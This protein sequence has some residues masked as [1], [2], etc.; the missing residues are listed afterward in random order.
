MRKNVKKQRTLFNFF[1]LFVLSLL[2]LNILYLSSCL[3]DDV[4]DAPSEELIFSVDTLRFDTVFT[5]VGSVTRSVRV[6]NPSDQNIS[7]GSITFE[8]N[9]MSKFRM[10]VD[11]LSGDTFEDVEIRARDSLYIFVEVTIDPDEPL[12][13]SP[14]IMTDGILIQGGNISQK[15]H[16]EAWGQNA[17]YIPSRFNSG[18]VTALSCR[19]STVTFD[20]PRPYVIYGVL[21]IDSCQVVLPAGTQVYV[22]GG[23]AD[24]NGTITNDGG[25]FFFENASMTS[26]G[27]V[28]APVVFQGDRLEDGFKDAA[29]QWRG[30]R[31]TAGSKNNILSHTIVK[32]AVIGVQADSASSVYIEKSQIFN[33]SSFGV[34]GYHA[35]LEINNSLIHTNS[36]SSMFF[37]NGGNYNV[38]YSTIAN[39]GNQDPGIYIDN[40]S[41]TD[42]ECFFNPLYARLTNNIITGSNGDEILYDDINEGA[43][44]DGFD[45]TFQNNLVKIEELTDDPFFTSIC[46]N[47][48]SVMSSDSVFINRDEADFHLHQMSPALEKAVIVENVLDDIEDNQRD[49]ETP[50]I[51][52]YEF[53]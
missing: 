52:C 18:T 34:F 43:N 39:Y 9:N 40:Y 42:T 13:I 37:K 48:T 15:I 35:D 21:F 12:S 3:E 51:G 26:L 10:N 19:N 36:S 24:F 22:H 41:C 25:F 28:D 31:F 53:Q 7:L 11:G 27:T 8:N 38:S 47:C 50:D 1:R 6:I 44:P 16:L 4:F 46:N 2:F 32:N 20:D 49:S 17:N 33:T 29:G 14:F 23:I 30:L 5:S 45:V